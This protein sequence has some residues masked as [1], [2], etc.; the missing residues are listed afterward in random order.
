MFSRLVLDSDH[1]QR[2]FPIE[3]Q[4][5]TEIHSS[6]SSGP[7]FLLSLLICLTAYLSLNH[8]LRLLHSVCLYNVTAF[9]CGRV[10]VYKVFRASVCASVY[11]ARAAYDAKLVLVHCCRAFHTGN[12]VLFNPLSTSHEKLRHMHMQIRVA[13]KSHTSIQPC[14]FIYSYT[15]T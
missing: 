7:S 15:Q 8:Y 2:L 3:S 6:K 10:A 1:P 12:M 5:H 4:S 9:I 11:L 13:Q 14:G